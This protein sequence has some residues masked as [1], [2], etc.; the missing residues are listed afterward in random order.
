MG[1]EN[2]GTQ[3]NKHG[4]PKAEEVCKEGCL[5]RGENSGVEMRTRSSPKRLRTPS[6][7]SATQRGRGQVLLRALLGC[8]WNA[9]SARIG[10]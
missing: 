9:V 4:C 1:T 6:V 2:L 3:W 8:T 5:G 7:T 10:K